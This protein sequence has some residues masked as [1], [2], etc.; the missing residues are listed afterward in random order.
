MGC[1]EE[2]KNLRLGEGNFGI[3]RIQNFESRNPEIS[4]WTWFS[5][6]RWLRQRST[7]DVQLIT[8]ETTIHARPTAHSLA[9][10]FQFGVLSSP[11]NARIS[12]VRSWSL[13]IKIRTVRPSMFFFLKHTGQLIIVRW[14]GPSSSISA[15][16]RRRAL[17]AE[18]FQM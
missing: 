1:W 10:Q 9:R 17:Q 7:L 16:T 6:S 11:K 14:V 8:P 2:R 4:D 5:L 15:R 13:S 12:R 3:G 18:H